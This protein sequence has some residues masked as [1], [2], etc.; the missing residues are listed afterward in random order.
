MTNRDPMEWLQDLFDLMANE[1][2]QL[3]VEGEMGNVDASLRTYNESGPERWTEIASV[4][5]HET[6]EDA[7]REL[8]EQVTGNA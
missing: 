1:R 2:V 6:F 4:T 8:M 7:M 3:L 5:A